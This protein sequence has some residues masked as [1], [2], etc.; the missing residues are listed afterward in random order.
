[1]GGL[2]LLEEL[3]RHDPEVKVI[4]SSGYSVGPVMS[5]FKEHGF[6]A[7]MPKPF[8]LS[9]LEDLIREVPVP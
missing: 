2:E 8:V 3:K 1:M 5:N 4:V 7:A 6:C 9:E